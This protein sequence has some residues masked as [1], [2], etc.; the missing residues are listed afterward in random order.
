MKFC[1]KIDCRKKKSNN[2]RGNFENGGRS[3]S[4]ILIHICLYINFE[5]KFTFCI[6]WL[7]R[8]FLNICDSIISYQKRPSRGI[9]SPS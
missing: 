4:K 5:I 9:V 3:K 8:K 1:A 6:Y 7:R 2:I